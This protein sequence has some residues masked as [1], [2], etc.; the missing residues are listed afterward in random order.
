MVIPNNTEED[1]N[2]KY[3]VKLPKDNIYGAE[4]G[5]IIGAHK[6]T[7]DLTWVQVAIH[8]KG[9]HF[10]PVTQL[11]EYQEF[12]KMGKLEGN[13]LEKKTKGEPTFGMPLTSEKEFPEN[14]QDDYS[15]TIIPKKSGGFPD[16]R[17]INTGEVFHMRFLPAFLS[18]V[19]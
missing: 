10:V 3:L 5:M 14:N 19:S 8:K 1:L 15:P 2:T 11:F 16:Y 13:L 18:R 4:Y 7:D 12:Q 17:D 6:S 9:S